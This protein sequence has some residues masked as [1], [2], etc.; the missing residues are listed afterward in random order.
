MQDATRHGTALQLLGSPEP[1]FVVKEAA[2]GVE[3]AGG[4]EAAEGSVGG[5]DA[6]TR[7]D[8]RHGVGGHGLPHGPRGAGAAD[9]GGQLAI[10]D[11]LARRDAAAGFQNV[12]LKRRAA[13]EIDIDVE[14]SCA[15][16]EIVGQG[17]SQ[18]R[19]E[20]AIERRLGPSGRQ[21]GRQALPV[22][23]G[24]QR[25]GE[26]VAAGD[27]GHRSPGRRDEAVGPP[28]GGSAQASSG[29]LKALRHSDFSRWPPDGGRLSDAAQRQALSVMR[30]AEFSPRGETSEARG[31]MPL[32]HTG[33]I[34][35]PRRSGRGRPGHTF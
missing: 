19:H 31:R 15:A 4:A 8:E 20:A 23:V 26:A 24:Q 30:S 10:G 35:V 11:D 6:V 14:P 1:P 12:S 18:G 13:V 33:R 3:A 34:P 17:G 9:L 21:G 22:G 29:W 7:D 32:G 2:L 25:G 16:G 28:P 5:D 27:K